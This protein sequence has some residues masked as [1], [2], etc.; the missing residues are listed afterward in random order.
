MIQPYYGNKWE[1]LTVCFIHTSTKI[2]Y[3][4]LTFIC[5]RWIHYGLL[6]MEKTE[7]IQ[8][9]LSTVSLSHYIRKLLS[10][11]KLLMSYQWIRRWRTRNYL[12]YMLYTYISGLH[13]FH[14]CTHR[15]R[16]FRLQVQV[17]YIYRGHSSRPIHS[18][19]YI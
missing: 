7:T 15:R 5:G 2:H 9:A 10:K 8:S 12:P 14:W 11:L 16:C 3:S 4:S 18:I 17:I 6:W 19:V 1:T 13:I